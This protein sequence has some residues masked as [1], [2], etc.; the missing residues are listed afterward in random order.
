LYQNVS[1]FDSSCLEE[2]SDRVNVIMKEFDPT[3]NQHTN[4]PKPDGRLGGFLKRAAT[5][6]SKGNGSGNPSSYN[7]ASNFTPT[8]EKFSQPLP[9]PA[10]EAP[11]VDQSADTLA[12]VETAEPPRRWPTMLSGEKEVQDAIDSG[13]RIVF[14]GGACNYVLED[15]SVARNPVRDAI[16]DELVRRGIIFFDPQIH[17]DSHGRGYDYKID[18]LS[19]KL[20]TKASKNDLFVLDARTTGGVTT[21]E[22]IRDKNRPG[23]E[24]NERVVFFNSADHTTR[25]EPL[26]LNTEAGRIQQCKQFE[27]NALQMRKEFLAMLKDDGRLWSEENPTG[28]TRVLIDT[29]N[30]SNQTLFDELSA[31]GGVH[32]YELSSTK[33]DLAKITDMF[34]KASAG[35]KVLVYFKDS[36]VDAEGNPTFSL[37]DTKSADQPDQ[38]DPQKIDQVLADYIR[39]VNEMRKTL[40]DYLGTD[41]STRITYNTEDAITALIEQYENDADASAS[42]SGAAAA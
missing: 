36:K 24:G 35:E 32:V 8:S 11:A 12:P 14:S 26:G 38:D 15:G 21:M 3:S 13:K 30:Q 39:E 6:F 41:P 7:E 27:K 42:G 9:M 34:S 23:S 10:P 33:A 22:I 2:K 18:G 31:V 5:F 1:K 20:A 16:N 17:K 29:E 37:P 28:N 19:E 25:F 4:D 40:T